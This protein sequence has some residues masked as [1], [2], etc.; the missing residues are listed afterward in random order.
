MKII[1][2]EIVKTDNTPNSPT[3]ERLEVILRTLIAN[4]ITYLRQVMGINR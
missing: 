4:N 3:K 2:M 1:I